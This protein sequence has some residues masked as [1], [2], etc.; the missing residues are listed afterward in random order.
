MRPLAS[1]LYFLACGHFHLDVYE[2]AS[3][4]V[5]HD[6]AQPH[7]ET[8]DLIELHSTGFFQRTPYNELTPDLDPT[9]ALVLRIALGLLG[10]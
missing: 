9:A 3:I 10:T 1:A 4:E 8:Y 6:R 2:T 5:H 7:G